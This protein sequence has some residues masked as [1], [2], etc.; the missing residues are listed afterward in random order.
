MCNNSHHTLDMLLHYL[1]K[2]NNLLEISFSLQQCKNFWNRLRFDKVIAKVRDHSFF[3][4]HSVLQC[5]L[6]LQPMHTDP[7]QIFLTRDLSWSPWKNIMKT[8]LSTWSPCASVQHHIH[9]DQSKHHGRHA[10][11]TLEW[12]TIMKTTEASRFPLYINL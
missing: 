10:R 12:D 9:V 8:D 2:Y 3:L 6:Y 4:G 1:V 11:K 7:S 5:T